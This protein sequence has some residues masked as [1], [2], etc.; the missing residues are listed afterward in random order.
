MKK[1]IVNP[2]FASLDLTTVVIIDGKPKAVALCGEIRV[3]TPPSASGP[4]AEVVIPKATQEE[5][6]WLFEQGHPLLVEI[7]EVKAETEKKESKQ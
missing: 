2:K 3:T 4:G 1:V 7:E 6:R 5:L